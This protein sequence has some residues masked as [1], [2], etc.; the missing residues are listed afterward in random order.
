MD[1]M[2]KLPPSSRY[3]QRADEPVGETERGALTKRV[4]DAFADGRL[5]ADSY[6]QF[7]DVIYAA[8]TLGELVPVVEQLPAA[9]VNTPAIVGEGKLPAGQ[10]GEIRTP[11]RVGWVVFGAITGVAALLALVAVLLLLLL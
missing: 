5:D 8:K 3:L 4:S 1:H 6:R 2:S 9:A 10:V 11:A 7:M